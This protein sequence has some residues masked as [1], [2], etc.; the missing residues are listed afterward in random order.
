MLFRSTLP[1]NLAVALN[2]ELRYAVVESAQFIGQYPYLLVAA[3]LVERLST[4]FE[5]PLTVKATILGKD[6][7]H[8]IYRH[9]L[10]ARESAILIGGDYVTTESGTGLV[11]TAPGHGQEDYLV[12]QRYGL[13]ILSPVDDKG[14]FT[15][16]AGQ[17]AGLNVLKDANEAIIQ[18]LQEK[19][20]LLREEAYVHKYPYDWRT[21]KPTIFRATEQWFASVEGFREAA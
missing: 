2:P 5:T 7:E 15:A 11:H 9:P 19:G 10:F 6:L 3:D 16:E 4:T 18:E 20:A 8:T 17:F 13:P 12:G 21:K 1:G 14:N